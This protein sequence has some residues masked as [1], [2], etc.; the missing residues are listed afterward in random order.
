MGIQVTFEKATEKVKEKEIRFYEL[1]EMDITDFPMAKYW[2]ISELISYIN[3]Q[4]PNDKQIKNFTEKYIEKMERKRAKERDRKERRKQAIIAHIKGIL[5]CTLQI[6][7]TTTIF[8]TKNYIIEEV[9]KFNP[10]SNGFNLKP[11]D[12]TIPKVVQALEELAE[13]N[14]LKLTINKPDG[15]RNYVKCY[16]RIK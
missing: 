11:T 16:T 7:Q 15:Y 10:F 12:I 1:P 9:T 14:L 2:S 4:Y 6:G 13:E 8:A 5:N 3:M